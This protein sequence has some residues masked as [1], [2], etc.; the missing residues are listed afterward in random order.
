M[1]PTLT[2]SEWL[3]HGAMLAFAI[4]VAGAFSLG[5]MTANLIDPVAITTARFALAACII[6]VIAQAGP[7]I[8]RSDFKS[9]WR[10]AIMGTAMA[11][12]FVLM[13]EGLKTATPVSTAAVFT[14][15]P[16]MSGIFGWLLL[17]QITTPTTAFWILIGAIGALWVIFRA[18]LNAVLQFDIGRG[19]FLF[20]IGCISHAFYT[21]LI[22]RLNRGEHP[23]IFTLG[24]LIAGTLVLLIWD[25]PALLNTSWTKLPMITWIAL[26]YITV[27]ATAFSFFML[28]FA[29]LR[30]P[31][32]KVM[33]YTYL[34][35]AV[36]ILW[37]GALNHGW[38]KAEILIGV[39]LIITALI[40]LLRS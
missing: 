19:E 6:A 11:I 20:F 27:V 37:E 4:S 31:A 9:P 15:I 35:P 12:Y 30:L 28:Q 38:P 2:R 1:S 21:P 39:A 14:L 25:S 32:S 33:S 26:A 34:T 40:G 18:D 36:V 5:A 16:I 23:I 24:M 8:R 3:G 22:R 29:S 7:G 10:Y 13:F 17:R